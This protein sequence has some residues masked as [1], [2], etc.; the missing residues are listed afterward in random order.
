MQS[1]VPGTEI[2]CKQNKIITHIFH[3]LWLSQMCCSD[4][5]MKFGLL[6]QSGS[7]CGVTLSYNC[8]D[9]RTGE[10]GY[11]PSTDILGDSRQWLKLLQ[12][13]LIGKHLEEPTGQTDAL[14]SAVIAGWF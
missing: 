10:V 9:I 6:G 11:S 13:V 2:L 12:V 3:S 14:L 8:P 7:I 4:A 5:K 1:V